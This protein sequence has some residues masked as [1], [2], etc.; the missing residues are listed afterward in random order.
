MESRLGAKHQR[1]A[2]AHHQPVSSCANNTVRHGSVS[3]RLDEL[4]SDP[5]QSRHQLAWL[6]CKILCFSR[7]HLSSLTRR[8]RR[9]ECHHLYLRLSDSPPLL[10]RRLCSVFASSAPR[11][12]AAR[13]V[14]PAP[15]SGHDICALCYR[16]L[17]PH[18]DILSTICSPAESGGLLLFASLVSPRFSTSFRLAKQPKAFFGS[19][20][21]LT[22]SG[23]HARRSATP[24]AG[25]GLTGSVVCIKAARFVLQA[26]L[27][28]VKER[29]A[30][31]QGGYEGVLCAA[32]VRRNPP[33]GFRCRLA[34]HMRA[35][36]ASRLHHLESNFSATFRVPWFVSIASDGE[37]HNL[38]IA[39]SPSRPE[40]SAMSVLR[41]DVKAHLNSPST[42]LQRLGIH[43][44]RRCG[45]HPRRRRFDV[46]AAR[47]NESFDRSLG[48]ANKPLHHQKLSHYN[49]SQGITVFDTS[50]FL[51][52]APRQLQARRPDTEFPH[53]G[54]PRQP[55]PHA[56]LGKRRQLW[57]GTSSKTAVAPHTINVARRVVVHWDG[58]DESRCAVESLWIGFTWS[59]RR[60]RLTSRWIG[61]S[62][63]PAAVT[64]DS[65][66]LMART[67]TTSTHSPRASS[68]VAAHSPTTERKRK[69]R[70]LA[71]P[72]WDP[73]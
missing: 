12:P 17:D 38:T 7:N 72:R 68:R 3:C 33:R 59:Q 30:G 62:R 41:V 5:N 6:P 21:H 13:R 70:L 61:R 15:P 25:A 42:D 43:A 19:A 11:F 16:P 48:H 8:P 29:A 28:D 58:V 27:R 18:L 45:Q 60:L 35:S 2:P 24:F 56:D 14:H 46:P 31:M 52:T 65:Y 71:S 54:Q 67:S 39:R 73:Q 57:Q 32:S 20:P 4:P 51:W 23:A 22:A 44:A 9:S 36:F 53:R 40:M 10:A 50:I 34:Y 66:L 63:F 47:L 37:A 49:V 64:R 1:P 55:R 69:L 26:D